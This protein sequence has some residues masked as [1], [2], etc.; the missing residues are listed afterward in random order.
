[1]VQWFIIQ[2][3]PVITLGYSAQ[4][5][6]FEYIGNIRV[7]MEERGKGFG[8]YLLERIHWEMQQ[9]GY[10]NGTLYTSVENYRAHLLYTKYGLSHR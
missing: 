5:V 2:P 8:R 3:Q 4:P 7:E 6:A 10:V 9:L 1:L